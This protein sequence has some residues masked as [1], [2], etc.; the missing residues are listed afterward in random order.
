MTTTFALLLAAT[1]GAQP[2]D[3][4]QG[5][6]ENGHKRVAVVPVVL[7]RYSGS[8]Q[9]ATVGSLGPRGKSL[10]D[11]LR[12][13]LQASSEGGKK[14][15]VLPEQQMEGVDCIHYRASVDFETLAAK[16]KAEA[17]YAVPPGVLNLTEGQTMDVE[18]WVG[19]D[20][21]LVR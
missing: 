14:F 2:G 7:A 4:G 3:I 20:D 16:W 12:L 19:Q 5:L 8:D 21:Y 1:L 18:L 15:E 11:A 13:H 10:A 6:I 17:G 9:P